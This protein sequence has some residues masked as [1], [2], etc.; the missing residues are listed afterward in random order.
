MRRPGSNLILG[1]CAC[2][3]RDSDA[4][5]VWFPNGKDK[6]DVAV[7]ALGQCGDKETFFFGRIRSTSV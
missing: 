7:R 6:P 2:L 4:L 3:A 1:A 5:A